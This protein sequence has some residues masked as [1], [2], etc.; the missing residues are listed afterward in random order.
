MTATKV[1]TETEQL[2]VDLE[3]HAADAMLVAE[4]CGRICTRAEH[5]DPD[6]Q[7]F[8]ETARETARRASAYVLAVRMLHTLVEAAARREAARR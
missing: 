4:R 7:A 6:D 8:G 3:A 5:A 2:L 1:R